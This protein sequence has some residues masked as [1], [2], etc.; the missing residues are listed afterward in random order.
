MELPSS[1]SSA[2]A[3]CDRVPS[4]LAITDFLSVIALF[5][6]PVSANIGQLSENQ[7]HTEIPAAEGKATKEITPTLDWRKESAC[8]VMVNFGVI[9]AVFG[10]VEVLYLGAWL[11]D[12]KKDE[13]KPP[14]IFVARCCGYVALIYGAALIDLVRFGP[15]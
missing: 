14:I 13:R 7:H 8:L 6:S 12:E 3:L 10:V 1:I 11:N 15:L 2:S 5:L 9:L 4:F